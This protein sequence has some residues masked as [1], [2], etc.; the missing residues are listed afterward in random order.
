MPKNKHERVLLELFHAKLITMIDYHR[1]LWDS[2]AHR[3]FIK[4][5]LE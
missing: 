2:V 3:D 1:L 4:I 5:M